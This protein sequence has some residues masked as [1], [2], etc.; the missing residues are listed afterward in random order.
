MLFASVSGVHMPSQTFTI[1]IIAHAV[2]DASVSD[3]SES[4]FYMGNPFGASSFGGC[5]TVV[6]DISDIG[7]ENIEN[8]CGYFVVIDDGFFAPSAW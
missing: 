5:T 2:F 6:H 8:G 7:I 3:A 4:V 1:D